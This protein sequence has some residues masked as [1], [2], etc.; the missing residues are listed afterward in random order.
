ME[1]DLLKL[2]QR[3]D[4]AILDELRSKHPLA[5]GLF[6]LGKS[7]R[8]RPEE[9]GGDTQDEHLVSAK[10]DLLRS[11]VA[12]LQDELAIVIALVF[13]KMK[14]VKRLKTGGALLATLTGLVLAISAALGTGDEWQKV[15]SAAFATV[16]GVVV[17]L[18]G[19]F[20]QAPSG[21]RI[22]SAEEYGKLNQMAA[23]LTKLKRRLDRHELFPLQLDDISEMVE[24]LD[25]YAAEINHL[26]VA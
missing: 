2:L 26:R 11:S 15:V 18:S 1:A 8:G 6:S 9:L 20:E 4:Q 13:A 25:G 22:A 24:S 10:I 12:P 23:E 14:L 5:E 17:V 7:R 3:S 21:R 19:H 16:G